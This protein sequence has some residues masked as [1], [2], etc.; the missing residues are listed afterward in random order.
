MGKLGNQWIK[1]GA[2]AVCTVV[3]AFSC[4]DAVKIGFYAKNDFE[5]ST[6]LVEIVCTAIAFYLLAQSVDK[7]IE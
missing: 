4:W 1:R 2:W 5:L 6:G 7:V 3:A